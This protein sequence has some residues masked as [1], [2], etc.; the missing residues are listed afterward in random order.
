MAYGLKG[1]A[2][3][4]MYYKDRK[5]EEEESW[6]E[7]KKLYRLRSFKNNHMENGPG[8]PKPVIAMS[9]GGQAWASI[10]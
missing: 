8:T 6:I 7:I 2:G 5:K 9:R 4:K 1:G 10:D 3:I